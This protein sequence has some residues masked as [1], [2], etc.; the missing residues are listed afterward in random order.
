[1]Y[2][3]LWL[4]SRVHKTPDISSLI[5][6]SPQVPY[7]GRAWQCVVQIPLLSGIFL[8][9]EMLTVAFY[10]FVY[11]HII[12]FVLVSLCVWFFFLVWTIFK[13]FLEFV[14]I[15]LLFFMFWVFGHK[16]CQDLSSPTRVQ[17]CVA[18]IGRQSL[19]QWTTREVPKHMI[20][21][22]YFQPLVL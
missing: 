19:N 20:V 8:S 9:P 14:T 15:F 6:V 16:A 11:R 2:I 7:F 12:G 13:V 17:T 22:F 1:M 4:Q 5:H 18:C 10:S 21:A 3:V